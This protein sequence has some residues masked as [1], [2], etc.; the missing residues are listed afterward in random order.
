MLQSRGYDAISEAKATG[1]RNEAKVDEE[2]S[3]AMFLK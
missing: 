1:N 3:T 2:A